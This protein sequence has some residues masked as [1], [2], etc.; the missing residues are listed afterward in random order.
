M[1]IEFT[2]SGGFAGLVKGCRID[3]ALLAAA[4]RE[5]LEALVHASGLKESLERF[6]E[7]ARDQKQYDLTIDHDGGCVRLTCD[8]GCV[9]NPA[10]PLVAYLKGRC[11][12]LPRP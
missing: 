4:E 7:D 5:K 1:K 10:Q 12:A 11:V 2:V 8:D 6:S 9:P 3:T